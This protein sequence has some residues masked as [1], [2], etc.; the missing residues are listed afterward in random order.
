MA[1]DWIKIEVAT[2]DKPEVAMIADVLKIDPD[3]VVGKLLRLW[4]WAD[5]N[6][7]DGNGII[8]TESFLDRL[9]HRKG[10]ASAMRKAGWLDGENGCLN[11]PGFDRHN[12]RTAKERADSNR[13]MVKSRDGRNNGCGN[14]AEKVQ[15]KPQPEKRREEKN[16]STNCNPL[17]PSG[18]GEEFSSNGKIDLW[19]IVQAYPRRQDDVD[20]LKAVKESIRNG[21]SAEMI[22][23][24]T[25]AIAAIIPQLPSG[26]HNIYVVSAGTFF[27]KE[28]WRD[29][30]QTWLRNSGAK[31]GAIAKPL[32]LGGRRE[33]ARL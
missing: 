12:G 5:M 32:N 7:V 9:T 26:A 31:N 33:G 25:R 8:V 30:P 17:S 21:A 28:K 14:V 4:A 19:G 29:D 10:F 18:T 3:A 13:R 15:Q 6:S 1:G 24:G 23:A 11:F 27:K 2:P 16:S 20:A 22:L